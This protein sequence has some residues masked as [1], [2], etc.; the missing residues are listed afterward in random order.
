MVYGPSALIL[1]VRQLI[2]IFEGR[3]AGKRFATM[4]GA[5]AG[6]RHTSLSG[7]G[8]QRWRAS[9]LHDASRKFIEVSAGVVSVV[10]RRRARRDAPYLYADALG[11]G[12]HA[13]GWGWW[14]RRKSGGAPP[15]SKTLRDE[16]TLD[17]MNSGCALFNDLTHQR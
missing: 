13:F 6:G 2:S 4:G 15:Q 11:L 1:P 5:S 12:R 8:H 7:V 14:G 16:A 10:G 9:A 3:G 17:L